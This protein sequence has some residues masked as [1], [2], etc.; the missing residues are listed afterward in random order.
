[1]NSSRIVA[2]LAISAYIS[3]GYSSGN[4]GEELTRDIGIPIDIS[5][6]DFMRIK[7]NA[8]KLSSSRVTTGDFYVYEAKKEK[9]LG[10]TLSTY[11]HGFESGRGCAIGM[12]LKPIRPSELSELLLDLETGLGKAVHDRKDSVGNRWIYYESES[13]YISVTAPSNISDSKPQP[14]SLAAS[15]RK[16][17][18]ELAISR[19][20]TKR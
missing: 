16:C 9:L 6:V 13:L 19:W 15:L 5:L 18:R 14:V 10:H 7:P 12:G 2:S 17:N 20:Q 8:T 4:I 3:L 11:G 1:M